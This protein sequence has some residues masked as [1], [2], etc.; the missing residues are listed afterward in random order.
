[1]SAT[2]RRSAGLHGKRR[3]GKQRRRQRRGADARW[4]RCDRADAQPAG[5]PRQLRDEVEQLIRD[6]L[7]GPVGGDDEEL[8]GVGE[9]T[10]RTRYLRRAAARRRQRRADARPDELR[11]RLALAGGRRRRGGHGRS[12]AAPAVDQLV[13]VRVRADVRVD[14]DAPSCWSTA[15]WGAYS[16]DTSESARGRRGARAG[17]AARPVRRRRCRSTPGATGD[18][19]P[20]A[21]GPGRAR[22]RRPR[23]ACATH[24]RP[25][26]RDAVPGQRAA[27]A[28]RRSDE[29]VAVPG[30]AGACDARRRRAGLRA[31]A[32]RR[33]G[34]RPA[35]RPRGRAPLEMLYRD[36]GRV[37]GRPRR[38][39]PR[40]RTDDRTRTAR[41]RIATAA[42]PALRGA[43]HRR[44]ADRR[45]RAASCAGRDAST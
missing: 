12:R 11:R 18:L 29:R 25:V 44:P 33:G 20:L 10:V 38:R 15:R 34:R 37:R 14:G 31:A 26:A 45:R 9:R 28:G 32:A 4:R 42:M 8:A 30:R 19:E 5:T 22:G 7:I 16:R 6:D 36:D 24:E 17:V 39:R 41:R 43:A 35:S 3:S 40:R 27:A 13:A 2:P 23:A 1:M 21:P